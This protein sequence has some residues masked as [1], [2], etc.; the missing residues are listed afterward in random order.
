MD[1]IW[2]INPSKSEVIGRCGGYEKTRMITQNRQKTKKAHTKNHTMLE[3][4]KKSL[5]MPC[6]SIYLSYLIYT[7]IT[8][9][10]YNSN[11]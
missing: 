10:T 5:Y 1:K 4:T 11:C 2:Y 8:L 6:H 3:S 9:R 7:N